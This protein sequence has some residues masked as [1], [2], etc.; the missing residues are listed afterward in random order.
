MRVE[1]SVAE[2]SDLEHHPPERI[3]CSELQDPI[4]EKNLKDGLIFL[5]Q[6]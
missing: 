6:W 2:L 3:T 5:Y 1:D 4:I